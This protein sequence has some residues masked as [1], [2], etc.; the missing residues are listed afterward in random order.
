MRS[1]WHV[2]SALRPTICVAAI[3]FILLSLPAQ[4]LELYLIDIDTA[5]QAFSPES[6]Q[7]HAFELI[8]TAQ[9][10]LLSIVTGVILTLVLWLGSIRLVHTVQPVH[11]GPTRSRVWVYLL[12]VLI[13]MTPSLGVLSGLNNTRPHIPLVD[14]NNAERLQD[15]VFAYIRATLALLMLLA[16]LISVATVVTWRFATRVSWM[17]FSHIGLLAVALLIAAATGIIVLLP[18]TVPNFVGTLALAFLFLTALAYLLTSAS[19]AYRNFGI[20]VTGLIIAAVVLFSLYGLNDNHRVEYTASESRPAQLEQSFLQWFERRADRAA[21]AD[22]GKPYPIYIVAAE[23]GGT[24]A[25]YHVASHLARLQDTCPNFAQHVFAI[26]AV[27]G[28]S[29]GGAVFAALASRYASNEGRRGCGSASEQTFQALTKAYFSTD[30]LAPL[31]GST[32]F[33]DML[34]RAIPIAIPEFDRARALEKSFHTAWRSVVET[35]PPSSAGLS[36]PFEQTL[37]ELWGVDRAVPALFLNTTAVETGS[38]IMLAPIGFDGTPT[39]LHI[40]HALCAEQPRDI[41]VKLANAVSL[42]ARVPWLTPAGWLERP[43]EWSRTQACGK[44]PVPRGDRL[45]LVDGAYFENSGLESALE[46]AAR[47]RRVVRVHPNQFPHGAQIKIIMFFVKDDFANRWWFADG[48]L[49]PHGAGELFTPIKTLL[50]TRAARTRSVHSRATTFDDDLTHASNPNFTKTNQFYRIDGSIISNTDELY[51][52]VLDGAKIFLPL[53]WR[54]SNRSMKSIE[55]SRG[56]EAQLTFD[57]IRY[58]LIGR[59]TENLKSTK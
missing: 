6:G 20:P 7:L 56:V 31:V 37:Q 19:I 32:L 5:A 17:L 3:A 18:V 55:E 58:E 22:A 30:F 14:A 24:Y 45:Y 9:H 27:S 35:H 54:L 42:S 52:I 59:D 41:G 13:A 43:N 53:G 8:S 49:S 15:T 16:C 44:P 50:N 11:D 4:L 2:I 21:F 29:L 57:L 46:M 34:Q 10:I 36:N 47:L 26:H 28:G 25:A 48:D 39:T 1:F 38:R 33:P 40:S 51:H 12:I 23:G